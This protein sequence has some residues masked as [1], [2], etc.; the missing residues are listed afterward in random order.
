MV[1]VFGGISGQGT[2]KEA[3]YPTIADPPIE[4]YNPMMDKW[5]VV[6]IAGTPCIAAF[7]WCH[8]A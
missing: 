5:E 2:G 1:Y 7:A 8:M 3:H 4:K 6:E